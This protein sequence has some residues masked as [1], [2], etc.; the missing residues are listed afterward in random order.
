MGAGLPARQQ[1]GCL[2]GMPP[3]PPTPDLTTAP[4]RPPTLP[5]RRLRSL[6][7]EAGGEAAVAKVTLGG[8]KRAAREE[9]ITLPL[10]GAH[11]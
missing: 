4:S 5:Q 2:L 1:C 10:N 11:P 7:S 3:C 9:A 6:G 8:E